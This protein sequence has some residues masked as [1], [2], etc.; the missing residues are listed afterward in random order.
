M[1]PA[2][3]GGC[4]CGAVRYVVTGEPQA[5]YLCHCRECRK[6]SGSAFGASLAVARQSLVV[7][8]GEPSF[9]TRPADS[10]GA[11]RCAFCPTCGSRLWHE[12]SRFE[13]ATVKAGTLDEP[14]DFAK[15]VHIWTARKAPGV[16]IPEG[17]RSF[18]GE[19]D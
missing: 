14:V 15:A 10:G 19:P 9:W 17:A 3:R 5:L 18:P 6:Q 2:M 4:Q 11:V 13:T 1:N 8:A 12:P 16:V 7:T